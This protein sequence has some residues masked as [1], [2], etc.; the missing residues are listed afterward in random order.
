MRALLIEDL[1]SGAFGMSSGLEYVPDRFSQTGELVDL[2]KIVGRY[3]GVVES[4]M[5]SEDDDKIDK[6]I[7]ELIAQGRYARAHISHIKVVLGHGARRGEEI[8]ARMREARAHG[9][10][11]SADVYPYAAG[12]ADFALD[13]P[14]WAQRKSDFEAAVR[15]RRAALAKAIHDRVM[16]RN[17]P[18][19]LLI[20]SG[21]DTGLTLTQAASKAHKP[22]EDYIIEA[23]YGGPSVVHFV[24]DQ[25]LQDVFVASP[26]VAISSDGA[27]EM[28]HPRSWGSF[29]KVI[30]EYV[31]KRHALTLEAAVRKMTAY[32]ASI[33]GLTD[34]GR[35][36]PGMKA[37]LVLF[38]PA[39]VHARSTWT[40]PFQPAA[41]FD[42]V[43][44]NG[45]VEW[46]NG[47]MTGVKAGRVLRH[48]PKG[49]G[50]DVG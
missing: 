33:L 47:A 26:L 49:R 15:D 8:L 23:G 43:A 22:F 36:A 13:Y 18:D 46:E 7:D 37:D 38:D 39:K 34:R 14:P 17:G 29:A 40:D 2:A 50:H 35:I 16:L 10:R 19:A 9:V 11:L 21:P 5:R 30:E 1:R 28:R 24:Q 45:K 41:G 6:A 48:R 44:V 20:E 25:V 27:P 4:H 32:P 31:V 42:M 3:D 12:V